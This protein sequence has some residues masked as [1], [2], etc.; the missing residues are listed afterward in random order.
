MEKK[1]AFQVWS[2]WLKKGTKRVTYV[3]CWKMNHPSL[4]ALIELDSVGRIVASCF[5][6]EIFRFSC[7]SAAWRKRWS[8]GDLFSTF[9]AIDVSYLEI[10]ERD[11]RNIAQR[12]Y[13]NCTSLN[14]RLRSCPVTAGGVRSVVERVPA[15]LRSLSFDFTY[16][17]IGPEA[18]QVEQVAREVAQGVPAG[19]SSLLCFF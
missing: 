10:R 6:V 1:K 7:V 16:C 19:L 14:I 2:F 15:Q 18:A 11:L 5:P 8:R 4:G 3:A 17:N 13:A 9:F 12:I